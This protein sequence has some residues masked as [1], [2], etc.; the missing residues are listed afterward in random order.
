MLNSVWNTFVPGARKQQSQLA[1]QVE[2]EDAEAVTPPAPRSKPV[3]DQTGSGRSSLLLSRHPSCK[4]S[5]ENCN[6]NVKGGTC[7]NPTCPCGRSDIVVA[8][9]ARV[10]GADEPEGLLRS[11]E[12]EVHAK[13]SRE[14]RS[15]NLQNEGFRVLPQGSE[16][17]ALDSEHFASASAD[18]GIRAV[19]L[20]CQVFST[21][22]SEL[23]RRA[24][25]PYDKRAPLSHQDGSE[26]HEGWEH[27]VGDELEHTAD[28]SALPSGLLAGVISSDGGAAEGLAGGRFA[29]GNADCSS[30]S[31]EFEYVADSALRDARRLLRLSQRQQLRGWGW[32]YSGFAPAAEWARSN[33]RA[34]SAHEGVAGVAADSAGGALDQGNA[35]AVHSPAGLL[36][37]LCRREGGESRGASVES[38][39]SSRGDSATP[40]SRAQLVLSGWRG[41]WQL[42]SFDSP[43][44]SVS[45]FCSGE[46]KQQNP[47]SRASS[48]RRADS[49]MTRVGSRPVQLEG[50]QK[51]AEAAQ[52][53]EA[54]CASAAQQVAAPPLLAIS[55]LVQDEAIIFQGGRPA[56]APKAPDIAAEAEAPSWLSEN[57]APFE[58]GYSD[59]SAVKRLQ[60][61][62]LHRAQ[63]QLESEC[64]RRMHREGW[65]LNILIAGLPGI[66]STSFSQQMFA[67]WQQVDR[68]QIACGEEFIFRL[69]SAVPCVEVAVVATATFTSALPYCEL[70]LLEKCEDHASAQEETRERRVHICLFL[71]P[72]D[73]VPLPSVFLALLK[74]LRAVTCLLPVLVIQQPLSSENLS[75]ARKALRRQLAASHLATLEEMLLP[76][77]PASGVPAAGAC[78]FCQQQQLGQAQTRESGEPQ[79]RA[80]K[81]C[82]GGIISNSQPVTPQSEGPARGSSRSPKTSP[83]R[84]VQKGGRHNSLTTSLQPE[85]LHSDEE[86]YNSSRVSYS[87]TPSNMNSNRRS[88]KR[89][90]ATEDSSPSQDAGSE[91]RATRMPVDPSGWNETRGSGFHR[92]TYGGSA[93]CRGA[94][95]LPLVLH[96]SSSGDGEGAESSCSR[97]SGSAACGCGSMASP[98]TLRQMLVEASALLL[99]ERAEY[100]C[101]LPF[102]FQ[103]QLQPDQLRKLHGLQRWEEEVERQKRQRQ[104]VQALIEVRQGQIDRSTVATRK[105]QLQKQLND[106][107]QQLQKMQQQLLQLQQQKFL[108]MLLREEAEGAQSFSVHHRRVFLPCK[109]SQGDERE[110]AATHIAQM[111]LVLACVMGVGAI[112]FTSIK[113]SSQ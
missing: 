34:A 96:L 43:R 95:Q 73:A 21:G 29:E 4:C 99:R 27:V 92:S 88:I 2:P 15:V 30:P 6:C 112:L 52:Q 72:H 80:V 5:A 3:K 86:S 50:E 40:A 103:Q 57:Q 13:P 19:S 93:L 12:D 105:A 79:Q 102:L 108:K 10:A 25:Q 65:R 7:S 24:F 1:I 84:A 56:G 113:N 9:E 68:R 62:F 111:G 60:D 107:R 70:R 85:G 11:S 104:H 44:G 42:T 31:T 48:S 53:P 110:E 32:A 16:G 98:S 66:D 97:W 75:S 109:T 51:I 46:T 8:E 87:D 23:S 81:S 91:E 101:F 22:S 14:K 89:K 78:P 54:S 55:S 28:G 49:P 18:H 106:L 36:G 59:D 26:T 94:V 77:P 39:C 90:A 76:A 41:H 64:Q 33:C 20:G 74:R 82:L 37:A 83:H 69:Q 35:L 67:E 47:L 71:V 45:S 63:R 61:L 17:L 100:G 58:N 38:G